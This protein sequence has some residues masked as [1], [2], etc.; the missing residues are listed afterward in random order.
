MKVVKYGAAVKAVRPEG[1][2]VPDPDWFLVHMLKDIL[3]GRRFRAAYDLLLLRAEAGHGVDAAVSF[4]T[5][6]QRLY[7]DLVGSAQP[8]DDRQHFK[9]R[10]PRRRKP[11]S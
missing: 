9:R 5:E 1:N 6:Q 3:A 2:D 11:D 4:W 10:R 8:T 7:P